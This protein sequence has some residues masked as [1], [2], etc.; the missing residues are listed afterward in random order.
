MNAPATITL[1][2]RPPVIGDG[3]AIRLTCCVLGCR[4]TFRRDKNGTPWDE[5]A[6]VMCGKHWRMVSRDRRRRYSP[7]ARLYKNKKGS[8]Q[9]PMAD[10]ICKLLWAEF[11]RFKKIATEAAVGIG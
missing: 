4:R 7:A 11:E 2:E 6:E 5:G 10:R 3:Q 9:G 8:L 1:P